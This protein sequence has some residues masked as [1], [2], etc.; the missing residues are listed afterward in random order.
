MPPITADFT[1]T[2]A[3]FVEAHNLQRKRKRFL[4]GPPP[5]SPWVGC[6]VIAA[7]LLV[8]LIATAAA[9]Y[10][11]G[12][13]YTAAGG[14][15]YVTSDAPLPTFLWNMVFWIL[16]AGV[17]W[18]MMARLTI[19]RPAAAQIIVMML[20][21]G[22]S[23]TLVSVLTQ[24]PPRPRDEPESGF[25]LLAFLPLLVGIIGAVILIR[26]MLRR[27]VRVAWDGQPQ[28][29]RPL[30]LEATPQQVVVTTPLSRH[31]YTW[32]SF[33]SYSEGANVFVLSLSALSYQAIPKRGF[34]DASQVEAF[35]A[36]LQSRMI[37]ADAKSQGFNVLPTPLPPPPLAS[38]ANAQTPLPPGPSL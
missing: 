5:R 19:E 29:Q 36:L 25:S 33:V 32:P 20:L 1:L 38:V 17:V 24:H 35:R 4:A 37:N 2:Y 27:M 22:A 28:L 31:E 8:T 9:V 10:A 21:L 34:A 15:S 13:T 23:T 7:L 6:A 14:G 12:R 18:L 11:T 16:V 26:T 30:H 3:E